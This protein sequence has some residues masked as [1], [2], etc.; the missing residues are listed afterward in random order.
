MHLFTF[1][2]SIIVSQS[3]FIL[4]VNLILFLFVLLSCVACKSCFFFCNSN[5]KSRSNARKWQYRVTAIIVLLTKLS[6]HTV[7]LSL[8]LAVIVL[9]H[10]QIK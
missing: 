4:F 7:R 2:F 5:G 1:V 8:S 10:Q 6:T 3:F 9:Y